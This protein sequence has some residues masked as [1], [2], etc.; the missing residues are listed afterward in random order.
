MSITHIDGLLLGSIIAVFLRQKSN[1]ARLI[2][3]LKYSAIV[4][5]VLISFLFLKY[6]RFVFYDSLIPQIGIPAVSIISSYLLIVLIFSKNSTGIHRI[7][8]NATLRSFGKY[9]YAIY[10]LHQ[11]VGI[12]VCDY[13]FSPDAFDVMGSYLPATLLNIFVS[14]LICYSLAVTSWHLLEKHFFKLKI[15]F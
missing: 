7:F 14:T 10:L 8:T 3:T 1:T 15:Y 6:G 13:V 2:S 9:S 5:V 11:P 12:A 4:A